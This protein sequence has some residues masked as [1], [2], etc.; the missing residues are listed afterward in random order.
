MGNFPRRLFYSSITS[1]IFFLRH[2]CI[3][4]QKEKYFY[5]FQLL[6]YGISVVC[7][8]GESEKHMGTTTPVTF[9]AN[10]IYQR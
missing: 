2:K 7:A 1:L 4:L 8:G 6:V 10:I 3:F 5:S 9:K